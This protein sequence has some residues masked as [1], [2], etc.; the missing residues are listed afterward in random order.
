MDDKRGSRFSA[1]MYQSLNSTHC[2][3]FHFWNEDKAHKYCID[4]FRSCPDLWGHDNRDRHQQTEIREDDGACASTF[5]TSH[6]EN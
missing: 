6:Q 1:V 4:P 5:L 3:E 2:N